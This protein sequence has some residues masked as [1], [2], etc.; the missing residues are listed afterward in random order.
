[1]RLCDLRETDWTELERIADTVLPD[2]PEENA[3][4]MANLRGFDA[5]TRARRRYVQTGVDGVTHGGAFLDGAALLLRPDA[6]E[7]RHGT[8]SYCEGVRLRFAAND[9]VELEVLRA[10]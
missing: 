1:V 6:E 9:V 8:A 3:K 5:T 10:V 7:L 2:R 4:W